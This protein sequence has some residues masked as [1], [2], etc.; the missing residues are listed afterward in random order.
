MKR[1]LL[2]L[3]SLLGLLA[4]CS[5]STGSAP[6]ASPAD[7]L[8]TMVALTGQAAFATA[9]AQTPTVPPTET[10]APHPRRKRFDLPSPTP[11]FAPGFTEFAQIRFVSPGPMS[12]LT[13]PFILQTIL[14]PGKATVVRWTCSAKMDAFCSAS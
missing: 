3:A 11:T 4:G 9:D 12:S 1:N 8:P 7:Y 10:P 6:D 13:S 2:L 14:A 5:Q